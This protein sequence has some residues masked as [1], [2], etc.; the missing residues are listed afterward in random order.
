ME[1]LND[2]SWYRL[3]KVFFII[4][5]IVIQGLIIVSIWESPVTREFIFCD[6]GKVFQ[7]TTYNLSDTYYW[8][9]KCDA[10]FVPRETKVQEASP[11]NLLAGF[12]NV[13]FRSVY[14]TD[15]LKTFA[16][17]GLPTLII[18]ILFWLV[19]R[20]FFYV[21]IKDK[22]L[23][24]RIVDLSKKFLGTKK[25][26]ANIVGGI[27]FLIVGGIFVSFSGF[28]SK[29]LGE[30]LSLKEHWILDLEAIINIAGFIAAVIV[31][32]KIYKYF[33]EKQYKF[34]E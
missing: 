2:K 24:G 3:L 23:A 31:F 28:L 5:F 33:S 10:N 30:L 18:C 34:K 14:K 17:V 25:L 21:F 12:K 32:K 6:N 20:I 8:E 27:A 11:R 29:G 13:N 7:Y 22:F 19:S 15:Y 9:K 1:N 16:I 26:V 4:T